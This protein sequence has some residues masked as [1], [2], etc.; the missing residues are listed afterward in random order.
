MVLCVGTNGLSGAV[1]G[2]SATVA[3]LVTVFVACSILIIYYFVRKRSKYHIHSV[4]SASSLTESI[5]NSSEAG[6][7]VSSGY[8]DTI[9]INHVV[10]PPSYA[11]T[12]SGMVASTNVPSVCSLP[13]EGHESET[14]FELESLTEGSSRSTCSDVFR[15]SLEDKEDFVD[16]TVEKSA[17]DEGTV[18][19]CKTEDVV[20]CA[21]QQ[22]TEKRGKEMVTGRG[23]SASVRLKTSR[24]TNSTK[25]RSRSFSVL[26]SAHEDSH[27]PSALILY[28]K[29]SPEVEL[30]VIQQCLVSDLAQYKIRTVSEDTCTF[31]ECPASWL[32]AQMREVSAVFCV[33][34]KAFDEEWEN[35]VDALSSLVPVFK[36]L[37]HGLVTSSCGRNQLLRDKIAIVLPRDSDL[38]YVPTYINSRPKFRL[39]S[40]DLDRMARFV[41]GMPEYECIS[42]H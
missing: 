12:C 40:H 8:C 15:D 4:T 29:G 5:D 17:S 20:V 26:H 25:R 10:D 41:T 14:T 18:G 38:Q 3:L 2:V 42:D 30:R 22:V 6:V 11:V 1:I 21:Q 24:P 16:K 19:D 13:S 27:T 28:S 9:N 23:R 36:Q 31:R 32:E 37:C 33:C 7:R 35:K 34:N 39:L